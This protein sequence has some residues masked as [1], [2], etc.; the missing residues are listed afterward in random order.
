MQAF[1]YLQSGGLRYAVSLECQRPVSGV[2]YTAMCT[3]PRSCVACIDHHGCAQPPMAVTQALVLLSAVVCY[4]LC[5]PSVQCARS[6]VTVSR[7]GACCLRLL[8]LPDAS[9]ASCLALHYAS[10]LDVS[11]PH[12]TIQR[13][14]CMCIS[15][16]TRSQ[17][18]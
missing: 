1:T 14:H 9:G 7:N 11:K 2:V 4:V 16:T 8:L 10:Q 13:W 15:C 5:V 17:L 3:S 18:P 6:V 12:E